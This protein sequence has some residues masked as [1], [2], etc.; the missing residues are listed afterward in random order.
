VAPFS[1]SL[2]AQLVGRGPLAKRVVEG[3]LRQRGVGAH[4]PGEEALVRGAEFGET[5]IAK[6]V[7]LIP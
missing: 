7:V 3:S 5:Y 2:Q 1:S 6:F 4:Q